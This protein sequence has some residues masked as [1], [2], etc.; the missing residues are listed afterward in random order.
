M[1]YRGRFAPSPTGPLH[2]GSLVAALASYLDARAHD[3][4][5]LL[6]IEDLDPLRESRAAADSILTSLEAHH[7][8]WD[9]TV[10]Y[11]SS[12]HDDYRGRL[13]ALQQQGFAY[14][15][16]CSRKELKAN[17]GCHPR[18]C[19]DRPLRDVS[20]PCAIRFALH[21]RQYAWDDLLQGP[22]R[23]TVR[24]EIDDFVL[25]RKEGFFAYQLA[26]VSD[27]IQQGITH[28]VRGSDLLD[29]TPLQLALY[30]ALAAPP[31]FFLHL[32]VIVGADGEK[33][34]KQHFAPALDDQRAGTNLWTALAA[35]GQAPPR[36]LQTA[37]AS[38]LLAWGRANWRRD[39]L[40]RTRA[41]PQPQPS[42][43]VGD[44]Y[45]NLS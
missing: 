5:W 9:E 28:V 43:P 32:P 19:R 27:D 2:F 45:N 23:I 22:Q 26:V 16:P 36:P 6:R 10:R 4:H 25:R 18:H 35:L 20:E 37:P 21:R 42:V 44:S 40:P 41:L 3:G 31:P 13:A 38:E 12:H 29:S 1:R 24:G 17:G 7:L 34:S 33:L 8:F 11:Q 14:R 15:C 39:A 30:E